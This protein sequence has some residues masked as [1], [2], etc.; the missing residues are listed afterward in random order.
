MYP[1]C[2]ARQ[3]RGES[4]EVGRLAEQLVRSWKLLVLNYDGPP[5]GRHSGYRFSNPMALYR[6]SP[7]H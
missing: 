7:S 1:D 4:G 6:N 5:V 2:I 3:L